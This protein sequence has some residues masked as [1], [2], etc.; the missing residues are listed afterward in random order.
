[1]SFC[2]RG[3]NRSVSY[4]HSRGLDVIKLRKLALQIVVA[5]KLDQVLLRSLAIAG[6]QILNYIHPLSDFAERSK[7]H[8]VQ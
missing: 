4:F 3:K 2:P 7:A 5:L 6:V 1:M 8:S